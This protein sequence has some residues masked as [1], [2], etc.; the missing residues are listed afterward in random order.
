MEN[1]NIKDDQLSASSNWV[2]DPPRIGD[3]NLVYAAKCSRLN[4][5]W[6]GSWTP[7]ANS[8]D[9]NQWLQVSFGHPYTKITRIAT[10]GSSMW[11]EWV[12]SYKLQYGDDGEN[13]EYYKGQGQNTDKVNNTCCNP[14]KI[15]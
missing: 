3:P 13:F 4:K 5:F 1:G 10:Q 6:P 12:T 14:P 8:Q 2:A 7:A 9:Q 11:P 15:G